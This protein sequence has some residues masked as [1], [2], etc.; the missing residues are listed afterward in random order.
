MMTAWSAC[1]LRRTASWML[2]LPASRLNPLSISIEVNSMS[3]SELIIIFLKLVGPIIFHFM[4]GPSEIT[5][6][7]NQIV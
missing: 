6:L 1:C 5:L 3:E 2:A 7:F 4:I